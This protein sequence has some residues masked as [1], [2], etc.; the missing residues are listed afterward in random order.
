MSAHDTVLLTP[1]D[2]GL[3]IDGPGYSILAGK[4]GIAKLGPTGLVQLIDGAASDQNERDIFR[5]RGTDYR[6]FRTISGQTFASAEEVVSYINA[7]TDVEAAPQRSLAGTQSSDFTAELGSLNFIDNSSGQIIITLPE[8]DATDVG[9]DIL[10]YIKE[11]ASTGKVRIDAAN[12]TQTINGQAANGAEV[13]KADYRYSTKSYEAARVVL[14]DEDQW[15]VEAAD[16][17]YADLIY[18]AYT[19]NVDVSRFETNAIDFDG[20]PNMMAENEPFFIAFKF[21]REVGDRST[22]YQNLIST[23]HKSLVVQPSTGTLAV[24]NAGGGVSPITTG[25]GGGLLEGW[26][27]ITYN[28]SITY[29]MW[30]DGVHVLQNGGY[31]NGM[32]SDQPTSMTLFSRHASAATIANPLLFNA[33]SMVLMGTQTL[34]YDE[35]LSL[36]SS[37]DQYSDVPQAVKDKTTDAFSFSANGIVTEKGTLT[38]TLR[39][40]ASSEYFFDTV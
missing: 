8:V 22:L 9:K 36:D 40:G 31:Y 3:D 4:R 25:P 13:A 18:A 33:C 16:K 32:G 12:L 11:G 37:I 30:Q 35:A 26:V 27:V 29:E 34:T 14:I 5:S 15:I 28:G 1:T 6:D 38:G 17:V 23:D 19:N 7:R 21:D 2:R 20:M 10:F 39:G 24:G